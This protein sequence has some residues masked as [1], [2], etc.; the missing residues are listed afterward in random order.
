MVR[1]ECTNNL[2]TL[3]TGSYLYVSGLVL[4][5][6]KSNCKQL[7]MVMVIWHDKQCLSMKCYNSFSQIIHLKDCK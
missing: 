2:L 1:R 4:L 3:V 6:R 7:P 5:T